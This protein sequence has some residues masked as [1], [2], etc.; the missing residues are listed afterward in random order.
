APVIIDTSDAADIPLWAA[1]LIACCIL[2]ASGSHLSSATAADVSMITGAGRARRR[3]RH[4]SARGAMFLIPV[5]G[6]V[7]AL[8]S[9]V[10]A[11]VAHVPA[12][13]RGPRALRV[14][15]WIP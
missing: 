8:P 13:V 15:R 6:A 10:R 7:S 3:C 12:P 5:P 4:R 2:G 11:T 1:L 9:R 14:W